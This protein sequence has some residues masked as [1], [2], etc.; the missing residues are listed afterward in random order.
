MNERSSFALTEIKEMF[1]S[2]ETIY[3]HFCNLYIYFTH[4]TPPKLPFLQAAK[5]FIPVHH[6]VLILVTESK[7]ELAL[8]LG[9]S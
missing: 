5:L 2:L 9:K 4:L 1:F 7:H 8:I 6:V 3:M